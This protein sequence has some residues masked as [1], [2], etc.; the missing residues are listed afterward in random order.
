MY[1]VT[2]LF[3]LLPPL[4]YRS[5]T[6]DANPEQAYILAAQ[7]VLPPGVLGLM[8]AAM[9]SATASMVSSQL[10]VFAGV[11]TN[12]FYRAF[13]NPNASEQTL[14]ATG[15]MFTAI[16]GALL[17]TVAVLVPHLGG[18]EKLIITVNS[19]LVVPL[20]APALWGLFSRKIGIREMCL[21]A[22]TSFFI[23]VFLRFGIATSPLI[24]ETDWLAP[25]ATYLSKNIKNLEVVV[26][27]ILPILMLLAL[28]RL[29]RGKDPGWKVLEDERALLQSSIQ[30]SNITASFDS[31]PARMVMI[32]LLVM[33]IGMVALG[34]FVSQGRTVLLSFGVI[35]LLIAGIIHLVISRLRAIHR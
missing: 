20:L 17:V 23:S 3:W 25:L 12:D 19:L 7:S 32:S 31:F 21:V 10:N 11:L 26:G 34:F 29:K 2:P 9:F 8:V 27:V 35:L 30:E 33:A 18:A 15:R 14:V 5:Q 16:L 22:L 24:L 4:L 6:S 28:E 13:F 1:L